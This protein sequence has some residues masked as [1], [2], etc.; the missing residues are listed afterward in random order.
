M[1][2]NF[3]LRCRPVNCSYPPKD[4]GYSIELVVY[5]RWC[6]SEGTCNE[7]LGKLLWAE[8]PLKGWKLLRE[9][10][11]VFIGDTTLGMKEPECVFKDA[12]CLTQSLQDYI[13]AMME[14]GIKFTKLN[15]A[16]EC[17]N[18]SRKVYR[19]T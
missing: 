5:P 7:E 13:E 18:T 17:W 11:L 3:E 2:A 12:E 9:G 1:K 6:N 19:T 16:Y 10:G 14:D 8:F 4:I 15:T